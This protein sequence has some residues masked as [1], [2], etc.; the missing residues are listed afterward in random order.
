LAAFDSMT[1]YLLVVH[2]LNLFAPAAALAW[3]MALLAPVLAGPRAGQLR[4]GWRRRFLWGLL[5]NT[6][7]VL[8]SLF[9]AS[10]GKVLV[11]AA[12]VLASALTQAVLLGLWRR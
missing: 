12:L 10:P 9:F 11:Y 8:A 5:V 3:L 4:M 7:V 2:A 1:A 6:L